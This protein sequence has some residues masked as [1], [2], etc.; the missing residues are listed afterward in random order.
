MIVWDTKPRHN[1]G[2]MVLLGNGEITWMPEAA[3]RRRLEAQR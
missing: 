1:D 3:F 2:R